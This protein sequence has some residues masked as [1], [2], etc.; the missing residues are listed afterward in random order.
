[1][2][3]I[4]MKNMRLRFKVHKNYK[5]IFAP[6][7]HLYLKSLQ[8]SGVFLLNAT[9]KKI[10]IFSRGGGHSEITLG[11][12]QNSGS[13]YYDAA[14]DK[15]FDSIYLLK[16]IIRNS[17]DVLETYSLSGV[18]KKERELPFHAIG[19]LPSF[20]T[21]GVKIVA[22][23][24]IK[25]TRKLCVYELSNENISRIIFSH[26]LS[27]FLNGQKYTTIPCADNMIVVSGKAEYATLIFNNHF[28]L[29]FSFQ[30][31]VSEKE[32]LNNRMLIRK[33]K[34]GELIVFTKRDANE[35]PTLLSQSSE[36]PQMSIAQ[37]PMVSKAAYNRSGKLLLIL[38]SYV[39]GKKL[40]NNFHI[41]TVKDQIVI[42]R[43][44]WNKH[45]FILDFVFDESGDFWVL[46]KLPKYS[47]K[48]YLIR[49]NLCIC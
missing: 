15:K 34:D 16:R 1:M 13:I 24:T 10:W 23:E 35:N 6:S 41:W 21:H 9:Q 38:L 42:K 11:N 44:L 36:V 4:S 5:F 48:V 37:P 17:R 18:K 47:K 39:Q 14:L 7:E 8:K 25:G 28:Y 45:A 2:P 19:M 46:Y 29:K 33:N 40:Q 3:D 32:E 12:A 27:G 43:A 49:G 20:F 22:D 31:M 26:H 30:Q